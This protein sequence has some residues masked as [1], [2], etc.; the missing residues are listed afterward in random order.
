MKKN[1]FVKEYLISFDHDKAISIVQTS[2]VSTIE[3][4]F[5]QIEKQLPIG[6]KINQSTVQTVV[7]GDKFIVYGEYSRIEPEFPEPAA[8]AE[9]IELKE[10]LGDETILPSVN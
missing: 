1:F 4:D 6:S 3:V 8:A 9:T 10:V 2:S 5:E 7:K